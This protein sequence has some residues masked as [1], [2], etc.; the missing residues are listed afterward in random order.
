MQPP[1]AA[2]CKE[3]R[4][5]S[6]RKG[7]VQNMPQAGEAG[8]RRHRARGVCAWPGERTLHFVAPL[9]SNCMRTEM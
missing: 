5:H 6:G 8:G 2:M 4:A 1:L 3:W 9:L 7:R